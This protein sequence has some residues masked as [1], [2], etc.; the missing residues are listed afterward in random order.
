MPSVGLT[1]PGLPG[2][3]KLHYK[4]V[5]LY[6]TQICENWS[7]RSTPLLY[8][9]SPHFTPSLYTTSPQICLAPVL[10]CTQIKQTAGGGDNLTGVG[11]LYHIK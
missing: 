11:L 1:K 7:A 8:T 10:V 5:Y 4:I 2:R 3:L 6:N 9:S